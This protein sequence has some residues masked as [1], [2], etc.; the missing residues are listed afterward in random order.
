VIIKPDLQREHF[1]LMLQMDAS[2]L[3]VS[4]LAKQLLPKV[5]RHPE[6]V[7]ATPGR[8]N[9]LLRAAGQEQWIGISQGAAPGPHISNF[10]NGSQRLSAPGVLQEHL[11]LASATCQRPDQLRADYARRFMATIAEASLVRQGLHA[12]GVRLSSHGAGTISTGELIRDFEGWLEHDPEST[13]LYDDNQELWEQ[14]FVTVPPLAT[15]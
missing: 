8:W 14:P 7:D 3:L 9:F 2:R 5:K 10:G 15:V 11:A 13:D 6:A 1:G 12:A 4:R